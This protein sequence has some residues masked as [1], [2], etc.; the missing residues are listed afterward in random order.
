L[1]LKQEVKAVLFSQ[2]FDLHPLKFYVRI[3]AGTP[4]EALN[5]IKS[6]WSKTVADFPFQ[7]SFLDD[8]LDNF[9]KSEARWTNIIGWAGGITIFLACL[10]LFGLATLTTV[11]RIKEIGVRKVLGASVVSI[12]KLVSKD[13][14]KLVVLA[15]L[16]ASPIAYY[17]THQWLQGYA[18]RIHIEWMVFVATGIFAIAIALITVSFQAIKAA[19][20]NPVDSLRS[21]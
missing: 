14:I 7:Y 8:N 12:I 10:G 16:I 11:N 3:N 9:Y 2:P 6:A 4:S 17:F 15:L 20:A 13:L 21:E 18:Y 19:M 5:I 1:P